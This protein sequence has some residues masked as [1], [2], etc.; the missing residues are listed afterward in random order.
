LCNIRP[1][2]IAVI[3]RHIVSTD[4][5]QKNVGVSRPDQR[6]GRWWGHYLKVETHEV[7]TPSARAQLPLIMC[8]TA[9][10]TNP[11]TSDVSD[12]TNRKNVRPH[13]KCHPLTLTQ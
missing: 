5:I 6:R 1:R 11:I 4:A 13:M 3:R 8:V 12:D 10:M 2:A 9:V 7:K